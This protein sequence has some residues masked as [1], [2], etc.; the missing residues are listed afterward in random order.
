[1]N[2]GTRERWR[3][4]VQVAPDDCDA[5]ARFIIGPG[6]ERFSQVDDVFSRSR[7]DPEVAGDR[8]NKF[9]STYRRP[10]A[11]WRAAKGFRQ[12]DYAYRNATWQV[13]DTFAEMHEDDDRRDGFLDPLSQLRDGA[14]ERLDVGQPDEAAKMVKHAARTSGADL[15]GITANDERWIYTER[16][17]VTA[18]G[19]KANDLPAG[20]DHVIVIGQQMDSSLI[21]TAPSALSGAATGLG[22]SHDAVVLLTVAQFIRNLGYQ[23]IA[24]MNDTALAIP[25]AVKAGLGE[26]AKNG[27]LITPEFGPSLRLGKIF[28]DMPLAHDRPIS[29]GVAEMCAECNACSK[30]CPGRAIPN[31]QPVE[32]RHNR[33][34]LAGVTK[35]TVDG[36]KCFN[37]WS[38]INSDC[39]VCIRV[40]P[41]TR[42]YTQRRNR[43]WLRLAATPLRRLALRIDK[44][45]GRGQRAATEHW[46]P[47]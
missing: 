7:Y 21:A 43:W 41:Y 46:W 8:A 31:S 17:S 45:Q 42:D 25:L 30:A 34:N 12:L 11:D 16:F 27:L 10:L 38:K 13:T 47:S 24:S 32:I 20:L 29:F 40:C 23:A 37:Y 1:M 3:R 19:A 15:V 26:Y 5:S 2:N 14:D 6:F 44:R 35:Y 4:W 18:G 22:Y 39:S 9:F 36:E 28:T 33:S